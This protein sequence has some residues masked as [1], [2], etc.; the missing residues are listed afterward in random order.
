MVGIPFNSKFV[1]WTI[2]I[3]TSEYMISNSNLFLSFESFLICQSI[4]LPTKDIV[5]IIQNETI[6]FSPYLELKNIL[7]IPTFNLNLLSISKFAKT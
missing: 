7:C 5:Q 1:T 2:D 3:D 6:K 4:K